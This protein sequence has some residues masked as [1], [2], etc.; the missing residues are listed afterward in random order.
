[1][2]L[3]QQL[4]KQ[5]SKFLNYIIYKEK[6]KVENI[7]VNPTMLL[8]GAPGTGKSKLAAYIA[9]KLSLPL[10]TARSDALVSSYLGS[11]S[12]NIRMLMVEMIPMKLVN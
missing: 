7:P 10:V 3:P 12:K 4:E 11:T 2:A 8:H 6:L 1:L 5:I 9:A